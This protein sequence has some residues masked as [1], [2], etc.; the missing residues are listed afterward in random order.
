MKAPLALFALVALQ[1]AGSHPARGEPFLYA[2]FERE[3]AALPASYRP[4]LPTDLIVNRSLARLEDHFHEIDAGPK[5]LAHRVCREGAPER[6]WVV[7]AMRRAAEAGRWPSDPLR[8]DLALRGCAR[9]EDAASLCRFFLDAAANEAAGPPRSF[10]IWRAANCAGLEAAPFFAGRDVPDTAVIRF[11]SRHP[12]LD[13]D[14]RLEAA[15]RALARG[16]DV[17]A[18]ERAVQVF[19]RA[20]DPRVAR[21]LLALHAEARDPERRRIFG[22]GLRD[23][24]DPRADEVFLV[25]YRADCERRKA[26]RESARAENPD[27]WGRGGTFHGLGGNDIDLP[28]RCGA[29]SRV[30]HIPPR[31]EGAPPPRQRPPNE[32]RIESIEIALRSLGH[33]TT[34]FRFAPDDA[35]PYGSHAPLLRKM[36]DRVS[37]RL[38]DVTFDEVRP[39]VDAVDLDRGPHSARAF[40]DSG[41]F[42]V[43]VGGRDGAPDQREADAIA[44]ELG[45]AFAA[46]HRV[47]A[48]ADGERF[49]F[50]VRSLG[51]YVDVEALVGTANALLR[52]RGSDWRFLV[53]D[54]FDFV[55]VVAG[56]RRVLLDAIDAGAFR[57][58][59]PFAAARKDPE[60]D[61]TRLGD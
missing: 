43:R 12:G 11:H 32:L 59:A 23:Q 50:A 6:E 31:P 33:E 42:D 51:P 35:G 46:P 3:P 7:D 52:A 36:A 37:P 47:D 21:T 45:S 27:G 38:D 15:V 17:R 1:F 20:D 8:L 22:I 26:A 48:Y 14:D 58:G 60:F 57:P 55:E 13:A 9:P 19:A 41:G 49:R 30:T 28:L 44:D 54:P 53:L 2:P 61:P 5:H 16:D 56:P 25:E 10:L 4:P 18:L 39:A 34:V 24:S 29:P 40:L